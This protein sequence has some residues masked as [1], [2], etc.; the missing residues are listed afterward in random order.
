MQYPSELVASAMNLKP[1]ETLPFWSGAPTHCSHCAI[2]IT[3]G[4]HYSPI[5]AG[6]FFSDTRDLA[7]K[8]ALVCW[9]CV[10]IRALQLLVNLPNSV[11][12]ATEVYPLKKDVEKAWFLLDP[13][14]PPFVVAFQ[15]SQR[16]HLIWRTP[17]TQSKDLILLRY[18][19]DLFTV[20]PA[21]IR[22]ALEI[23]DDL[24]K[25]AGVPWLPPMF[26]DRGAAEEF[27]GRLNPKAIPHLT[28][29]E[30]A[31]FIQLGAGERWALAYLMHSKRPDPQKPE[32]ST[33]KI[34]NLL[35]S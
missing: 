1:D 10:H 3:E 6:E 26:L 18:G 24:G 13:P 15:S 16:Q 35:E 23:A 11:I 22:R 14:E 30:Q 27:H 17:V 4:E 5:K 34:A 2:P 12:T 19:P 29:E 33:Q 32:P 21:L 20:R 7:E 31:F 8:N 25:R 28:D 9:R